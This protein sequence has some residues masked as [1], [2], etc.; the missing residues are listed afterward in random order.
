M[1][2]KVKA[3]EITK[4][5]DWR[6][7]WRK[8]FLA[9]A[10]ADEKVDFLVADLGRVYGW[11]EVLEKYPER[12]YNCG[13]AEQNAISVCAGMA[14]MGRKPFFATF[15]PFAT[16]RV[17]E[18]IRDDCCYA[19][20][21]V[22]IIGSDAGIAMPKLGSTHFGIEDMAAALSLPNLVV[23]APSD[24]ISLLRLCEKLLEDQRPAYIRI[25]GDQIA[26]RI[27]KDDQEFEIGRAV[28]LR[29]G[30]A[31]TLIAC[32]NMVYTALEAAGI[33][34][35][36]GVKIRVLDMSTVSPIDADAVKKAAEETGLV[37]TLE[38]HSIRGGLGSMTAEVMA[39]QGCGRL[40]R[41]GLA[42][43]YISEV[44]AY[45]MMIREM[46]LDAQGVARRVLQEVGK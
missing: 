13:I 41:L 33:L 42:H 29:E 46:E 35:K 15:A 7:A 27:Y 23:L 37:L 11:Q 21:P 2:K 20:L 16:L 45:D 26:H 1:E 40:V 14:A 32:G 8:T 22:R 24:P 12:T 25:S 43:A 18:Q 9:L 19:E 44:S 6:T 3:F 38:E 10:Q 31:A 17:L 36:E 30:K 5:L 34:E 4:Q 28:K 39:E